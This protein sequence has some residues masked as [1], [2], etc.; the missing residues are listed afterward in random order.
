[1]TIALR[2]IPCLLWLA[3][4]V[5]A[6]GALAQAG[7]QQ[8][9]AESQPA[10]ENPPAPPP[11]ELL[12][13]VPPAIDKIAPLADMSDE[14][15]A[16][17]LNIRAQ[18]RDYL[19]QIRLM[20]HQFLGSK[21][22]PELRAQGIAQISE[23]TDPASFLP[24][25]DELS[26]EQDDVRTAL[27]DHF[28]GQGEWGQAALAW[29]AIHEREDEAFH[30]EALTRLTTPIGDP[31]LNVIEAGLRSDDDFT[32]NLAGRLVG[33]LEIF[34]AIPLLIHSQA[35]DREIEQAGDL[36]WIAIGRQKVFVR[37][38]IPIL[39][40]NSGAFMPVPGVLTE[41]VVMR[42]LDAVA[43]IYRTEI[44]NTLVAMTSDDWGRSTAEFGYDKQRWMAWYNH[45]YL[46]QKNE[47]IRAARL[48]EERHEKVR[49][50]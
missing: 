37:A 47:E 6:A 20:K 33:H 45:E 17:E 16:E 28:A 21:R 29:I 43:V 46:P 27:L 15:T 38:L 44:H 11:P 42:V 41:G 22:N 26:R 23:F 40:D 5:P 31:A 4:I 7:T 32:A 3:L 2:S 13:P 30:Y 25:I 10:S 48:A 8:E 35:A 19:R 1:M 49:G 18:T 24:L 50:Q 34:D 36:A 14:P 12:E 39:G 9:A